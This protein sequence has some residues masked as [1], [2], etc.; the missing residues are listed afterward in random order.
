SDGD[1]QTTVVREFETVTLEAGESR[2]FS[3]YAEGTLL[4]VVAELDAL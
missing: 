4:N 1:S 3:E 2:T